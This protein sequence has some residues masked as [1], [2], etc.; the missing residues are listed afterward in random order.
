MTNTEAQKTCIECEETSYPT[1]LDICEC[2]STE[3][4]SN[5]I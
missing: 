3:F 1:D 4:R 5:E 2:G